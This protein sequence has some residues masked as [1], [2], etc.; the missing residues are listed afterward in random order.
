MSAHP[1][2]APLS[3]Q[4]ALVAFGLLAA[5]AWQLLHLYWG[6]QHDGVL[7]TMQVLAHLHPDFYANDVFLRYGSQDRYTLFGG[8]YGLFIGAFGVDHA[9][10]LLTLLSQLLL[11]GCGWSLAR[12]L[13]APD[14]A[15]L[16]VALLAVLELPYGSGGVFTLMED[17]V[18]PRE[19]SEGLVLGAMAALLADRRALAALLLAASA[20]IHPLMALGGILWLALVQIG[21]YRRA[22]WSVGALLLLG[23]LALLGVALLQ[24][25][26]AERRD[27]ALL[28]IYRAPY[29]VLSQWSAVAWSNLSRPLAVLGALAIVTSDALIRRLTLAALAVCIAGLLATLI[30]ADWLRLMPVLQLQPW[31]WSWIAVAFGTLMLPALAGQLWS[32]GALGRTALALLLTVYFFQDEI[33]T[34]LVAL[35]ALISA[36]LAIRRPAPL[37][38]SYQQLILG[39]ALSLMLIGIAWDI[40]NRFVYAK[41]PY[42]EFAG[43]PSVTTLRRITRGSFFPAVLLLGCWWLIFRV[44]AVAVRRSMLGA[45]LLALLATLLLAGNRYS[46]AAYPSSV[47][48]AFAPWRRLIAPGSEVLWSGDPLKTWV[49]LERP[50]FY[51]DQQL[52][53]IL[54]SYTAATVMQQ[55]YAQLQPFLLSEG[56]VMSRDE[57]AGRAAQAVT[58]SDVCSRASVRYVVTRHHFL[59]EPLAVLPGNLPFPYGGL[60]LFECRQEPPR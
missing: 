50:T 16:A 20:M 29:L 53:T 47:Y 10:A 3:S 23:L 41:I 54:F 8:L 6:I 11:L 9:A 24:P 43:M 48:A 46:R 39:G 18:T 27:W 25:S 4:S 49:Y 15:L 21:T 60:K 34:P 30:G 36:S 31:R 59:A 7:Y 1:R 28:A 32:L 14:V 51:A 33:Y 55:R 22:G 2:A 58:L 40:A 42:V 19:L 57:A 13:N 35:M 38:P 5:A 17:F 12:R 26:V 44:R 56:V 37:A 52:S 45:G